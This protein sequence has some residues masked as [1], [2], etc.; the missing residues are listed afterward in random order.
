MISLPGS[1]GAP[2][3][4]LVAL[5]GFMGSGKTTVGTLLARHLGWRFADLDTLIQ[6]AAGHSIT[7]IFERHGGEA[8][9]RQIEREQLLAALGRAAEFEQPTV[10]ALGGG[11]IAQ[12]GNLELLR[13]AGA[14]VVWLDCPLERLIARCALMTTRPLFRDE[15]SFRALYEQRLPYYRQADFRVET[16]ENPRL[17]VGRV[18]ALGIFDADRSKDTLK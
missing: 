17:V 4:R 10:L 2:R 14:V 18:L 13:A 6:Q 5:A 12:P 15:A 9:F 3:R 1:G 7:E 11:T 8:V 16:V